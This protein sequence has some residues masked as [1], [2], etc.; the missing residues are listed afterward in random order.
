MVEIEIGFEP[1]DNIIIR[2]GKT[3]PM[4][5]MRYLINLYNSGASSSQILN[6]LLK[7]SPP[8]TRAQIEEI[9]RSY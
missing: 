9:M 1:L 3:L 4:E 7:R 5:D 6:E 8:L 2:Y